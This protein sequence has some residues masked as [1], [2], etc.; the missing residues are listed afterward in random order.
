VAK[1]N[2]EINNYRYHAGDGTRI[3]KEHT[4]IFSKGEQSEVL[5]FDL[6]P[7]EKPF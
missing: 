4:L 6:R 5:I 7:N 1:G 2:L 3:R